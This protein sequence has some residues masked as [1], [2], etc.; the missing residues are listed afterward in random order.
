MIDPLR[1]CKDKPKNKRLPQQLIYARKFINIIFWIC[2]VF[3]QFSLY[4]FILFSRPFAVSLQFIIWSLFGFF[5][6][7]NFVS[8]V[9]LFEII[10][11]LMWKITKFANSTNKRFLLKNCCNIHFISFFWIELRI[12]IWILYK[13]KF[14]TRNV[15]PMSELANRGCR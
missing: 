7:W 12:F 13:M 6:F 8:L 10:S 11:L 14:K 2:F 5:V 4:Y 3:T 1:H 15:I 9:N